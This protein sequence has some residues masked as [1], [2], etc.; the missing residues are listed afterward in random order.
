MTCPYE[1]LGVDRNASQEDIKLAYRKAIRVA[2]PD[3]QSGSTEKA[4]AVNAAYAV[5]SDETRREHYDRTGHTENRTDKLRQQILHSLFENLI[6]NAEKIPGDL[7][8]YAKAILD[9]KICSNRRERNKEQEKLHKLMRQRGRIKS[10][11]TNIAE[12]IIDERIR[13][14][15]HEIASIS[16]VVEVQEEVLHMLD[17]YEDTRPQHEPAY[18]MGVPGWLTRGTGWPR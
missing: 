7:I 8:G 2:H 3:R 18:D 12:S 14:F 10:K 5:L 6:D 16:E 9:E 15:E 4:Q 17:E 1:V 13:R 11:G